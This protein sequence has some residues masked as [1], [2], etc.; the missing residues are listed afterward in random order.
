MSECLIRRNVCV[1]FGGHPCPHRS[2]PRTFAA[3]SAESVRRLGLAVGYA[4]D[5]RPRARDVDDFPT[6]DCPLQSPGLSRSVLAMLGGVRTSV[7]DT[8]SPLTTCTFGIRPKPK[9]YASHPIAMVCTSASL[10]NHW[11]IQ[12]RVAIRASLAC[13]ECR[14][15]ASGDRYRS[16]TV[17]LSE[18]RANCHS[19]SRRR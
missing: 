18:P 8:S 10:T 19:G 13:A 7:R 11:A 2:L 15:V 1:S 6:T 14:T 3:S 16:P 9:L 12:M 17:L 4:V 5:H